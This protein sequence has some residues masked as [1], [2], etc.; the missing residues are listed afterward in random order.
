MI[1]FFRKI[2]RQLADENQFIKYTRYAIGEIVLVVIGIL[3]A[4]Q[5]NNWNEN[6]KKK[7]IE[8]EIIMQLLQDAKADFLFFTSRSNHTKIQDTIYN[9]L[10]DLSENRNV[11]SISSIKVEHNPFILNMA[12]QSNLINNNPNAYDLLS[13]SSIKTKLR[14]YYSKYDYVSSAIELS[15]ST[16]D[17]YGTPLRIKYFNKLKKI[18][19]DSLL[20]GYRIIIQDKDVMAYISIFKNENLNATY[21]IEKFLIVNQELIQLLS[22]YI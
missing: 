10:I 7:N 1:N 21:Q 16:Y 18:E 17:I 4:L 11:D 22:N 19:K 8:Y 15:N 13:D 6:R 5:I 3:I 20:K 2:R 9:N 12:Y 14:E